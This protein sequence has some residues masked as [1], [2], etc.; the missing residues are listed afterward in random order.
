MDRRS[1]PVGTTQTCAYPL[2]LS[3]FLMAI[4]ADPAAI[5]KSTRRYNRCSD[6]HIQPEKPEGQPCKNTGRATMQTPEIPVSEGDGL[7]EHIAVGVADHRSGEGVCDPDSQHGTSAPVA[8]AERSSS[9]RRERRVPSVCDLIVVGAG[10]AGAAAAI[11]AARGGARVRVFEKA[12]PGRDKSCGDGLTPEAIKAL[13]ELG[14]SLGS[15]HHIDG[16]R[17]IADDAHKEVAW[18]ST[19]PSMPRGAVWP[20]RAFDRHLVNAA[21]QAG[22]EIV[23]N[24]EAMPVLNDD[25]IVIG[26]QT[27]D[28]T[29]G[30]AVG[31][32]HHADLVALASGASGRAARMLGAE[33]VRGEPFA[34]AIRTYAPTPRHADRHLE[35]CFSLRDEDGAWIPGYGWMFPVGDGTVNIG[36]GRF[37]VTNNSSSVNLHRLLEVYR[38]LTAEEWDLGDYSEKPRAWRLPMSSVRRHGSGWA[39]VGDAA[40]LINPLTGEGIDFALGSGVLLAD[41]FLEDPASA[42]EAYDCASGERFDGFL[43][44]GRRFNVMISQPQGLPEWLRSALGT[45]TRG[46]FMVKVMASLG[47]DGTPGLA[48]AVLGIADQGLWKHPLLNRAPAAA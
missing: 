13:T 6:E 1:L 35:M 5:I 31:G 20:R 19:G 17:I 45:P 48:D 30:R 22:A 4:C 38:R 26:V 9:A 37:S 18:P 40:G 34:V 21:E 11:R 47:G 14:I 7:R 39:A 28:G 44:A 24:T 46:E 42:P 27:S 12:S 32:R 29:D 16:L 3:A 8:T 10:P 15:A 36:V 2:T 43:R 25:G 41:L 23:W 33:R